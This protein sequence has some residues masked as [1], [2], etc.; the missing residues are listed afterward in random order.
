MIFWL[1]SGLLTALSLSV[2]IRPLTKKGSATQEDD[3]LARAEQLYHDQMAEINR[4]HQQGRL[5]DEA[6]KDSVS[7]LKR[8]F[9]R[10]QRSRK[11]PSLPASKELSPP[12]IKALVASIVIAFPLATLGLYFLYGSPGTPSLPH[13]E[14]LALERQQRQQEQSQQIDRIRAKITT[15]TIQNP[16]NLRAWLALARFESNQGDLLA[17]AEAFKGALENGGDDN[18]AIWSNYGETLI[19]AQGGQVSAQAVEALEKS[20]ARNATDTRALF[21]SGLALYQSDNPKEALA[22]WLELRTRLKINETWLS[23]V[24]KQIQKTA[25][26]LNLSA[27]Q[28][29]AENPAMKLPQQSGSSAEGI[30]DTRIQ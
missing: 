1:V 3:S 16:E 27:A 24:D 10:S 13:R 28:L 17:A 18:A 23:L 14:R 21:Y 8:R 25:L 29:F 26:D 19:V 11:A 4:D 12:A 2:L 15:E 20:L 9:L 5:N 22:L 6:C 30:A 7:E